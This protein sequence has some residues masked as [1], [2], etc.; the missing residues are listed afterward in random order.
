MDPSLALKS[1]AARQRRTGPRLQGLLDDPAPMDREAKF[2]MDET[3]R[4]GGLVVLPEAQWMTG[5]GR[6]LN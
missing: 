5:D 2:V 3:M 1:R 6:V 4:Q